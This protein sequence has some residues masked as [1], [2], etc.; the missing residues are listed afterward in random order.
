MTGRARAA[1]ISAAVSCADELGW[2][3]T[4]MDVVRRRAGVSNGSLF[5][6]F[7]TRKALEMAV[8]R[9]GLADHQDALLGS[10]R[11]AKGARA[12]VTSVVLRHCRW[13]REHRALAGLF[14]FTPVDALRTS[15]GEPGMRTSRDFYGEIA[16]WLRDNGWSGKPELRV[17]IALWIGPA[18]E[19]CRRWLAGP[20][21]VGFTD[22]ANDL[23][24]GAWRSLRPFLT[25][26]V[27]E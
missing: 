6:H 1:I 21:D 15:V 27:A 22:A 16:N 10:L 18:H 24:E 23:A 13:V 7:P 9:E 5:H 17:V 12:G 14:L 20:E 11:S 26:E 8:L 25:R 4:S 2:S 19:Y 3:A